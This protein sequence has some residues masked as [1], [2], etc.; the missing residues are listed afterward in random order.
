MTKCLVVC[1]DGT[2]N[3]PQQEDNGIPAPSNVFKIHNAIDLPESDRYYHPGVGGE[4]GVLRPIAAGAFG[5]GISRHICSAYHWLANNYEEGDDIY[6]YGF[7]RGAFTARSLGAF[8]GRGLL[9]LTSVKPA[10]A[11]VRVHRAY[12]EAYRAERSVKQLNKNWKM[13]NA[14]GPTPIRFIGVWDTVGA[15]GVPDDFEILNLFDDANAWCFHNTDLGDHVQTGRH[16]MAIDEIRSSFCVTRWTN[17]QTHKDVTELWFPGVHSDVGGGYASCGLSD[18]ALLWMIKESELAGL[19][20]HSHVPAALSPNAQGVLHNSYKGAFNKLRSR[21]RNLPAMHPASTEFHDSALS[22]QKQPPLGYPAYHSTTIL[23]NDGDS[24]TFSVFANQHWNSSGVFLETGVE[25]LFDAR[26]EWLDSKDAC[27][28]RGTEDSNLTM[29]DIIRS[30][31]GFMGSAEPVYSKMTSNNGTDFMFTKRVEDRSW[32]AL[33]GAIANDNGSKSAVNNDGSPNP[34]QY[35]ELYEHRKKPLV[36][37]HPGYLYC[38]PNDVWALYGNNTG[39][40]RVTV[41]RVRKTPMS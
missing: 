12:K 22:R 2:W 29:G 27:D 8:L 32:F 7:S 18:G 13:F 35:V 20:F 5:A 19:P 34:H 16:A 37:H 28:W 33:I 38:F 26:G 25:Y 41:K 3:N 31:A 6:L 40:L 23:S 30:F 24:T 9:N 14:G 39:S 10:E 36:L 17:R 4:G 15:L 1:C 11:W 21:P